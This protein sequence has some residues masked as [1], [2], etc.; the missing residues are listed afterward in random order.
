MQ[1][2][3]LFVRYFYNIGAVTFEQLEAL[4][5][6]YGEIKEIKM[7]E[8]ADFAIIEM[9]KQSEAESA[10]KELHG[11][12]LNGYSL[13]VREAAPRKRRRKKARRKYF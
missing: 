2:S 9:Y 4:F 8:R 6:Y 7:V 10:K 1:S 11:T 13:K 3:K 5:S 12:T